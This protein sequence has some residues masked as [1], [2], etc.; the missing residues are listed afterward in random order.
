MKGN[1]NHWGRLLPVLLLTV[2]LINFSIVLTSKI[3]PSIQPNDTAQEQKFTIRNAYKMWDTTWGGIYEDDSEDLAL[4]SAGN[5]YTVGWTNKN[6]T[7]SRDFAVVKFYP[8]GIK[9]WNTTWGG[10]SDDF[11]NGIAVD[12]SNNIYTV[13]ITSSFGAGSSNLVVV[14]FDLNGIEVWNTT[15]GSSAYEDG[16]GIALDSAGNIYAVGTTYTISPDFSDFSVVKFYPNGTV[17]W[18]TTWGGS[19]YNEDGYEIALDTAGNIY[20]VGSTNGF[21]AGGFDLVV[22]KFYPDGTVAWNTTWGGVNF[23]EGYGIALDPAGNIYTVG[24]TNSFSVGL[25]DLVVVKF[26]SNGTQAWNTTWGGSYGD[27]GYGIALDP[28]GNIYTSGETFSFGAGIYDLVMVKFYP[29]GMKAWNTTWGGN[30]FDKGSKIAVDSVGNIYINGITFSYGV[31]GDFVVVKFLDRSTTTT[32]IS[33]FLL[34][35]VIIGVLLIPL[36]LKRKAEIL[37]VNQASTGG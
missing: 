4:D 30:K 18:N 11:G 14:K 20:T 2:L 10:G 27:D 12:S 33:G 23:D 17:A 5:I 21:G 15:W 28:T 3:T 31:G 6:E 7:F 32:W 26:H 36:I 9:A 22:V 19:A 13:G 29:N 37:L 24:S 35:P 16:N 8:N 25:S 1:S 34:I